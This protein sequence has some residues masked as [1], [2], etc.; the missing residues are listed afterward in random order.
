MTV[1]WQICYFLATNALKSRT[2]T[3][4]GHEFYW[5]A[6]STS[7]SDAREKQGWPTRVSCERRPTPASEKLAREDLAMWDARRAIQSVAAAITTVGL[8][9]ASSNLAEAQTFDVKQLEV[10]KGALEYGPETMFARGVPHALGPD[11]NRWA[12]EQ[13][14]LYGLTDWW[15]ISAALKFE[16]PEQ[17]EPRLGG[18]GLASI[19]VLKALEDKRKYDVGFGWYTEL[20]ASLNS[21]TTNTVLFGPIVS[22]KADRLSITANPF[23][24][25]SFGRNH[26]EGIAFNYAWQAKYQLREGLGVG[27]EG[28]GVVDD[29]GSAPP[30]SQQ[31]HRIG[32]VVFTELPIRRDFKLVVDAGLLFGLTEATPDVALKLNFGVP[33]N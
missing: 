16:K 8:L 7:G 12:T 6:K 4:R 32:P 31:E 21:E 30:L 3:S 22:L 18:L 23:F 14:L 19:F 10:T 13:T 24:E 27:V 28:F 15:K 25:Q 11:I 33:L 5:N 2:I 26:E 29:I 9:A 1:W 20:T 17:D